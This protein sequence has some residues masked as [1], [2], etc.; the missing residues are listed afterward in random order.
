MVRQT[1]TPPDVMTRN[2]FLARRKCELAD[3]FPFEQRGQLGRYLSAIDKY[4]YKRC[5]GDDMLSRQRWDDY[6]R[7]MQQAIEGLPEVVIGE[8]Q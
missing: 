5:P 3:A 8:V 4:M 1:I 2:L 6:E 7:E